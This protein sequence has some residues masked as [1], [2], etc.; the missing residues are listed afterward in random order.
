MFGRKLYEEFTLVVRLKKQV[1]VTDPDWQD[2]LHHVRHGCCRVHHIAMLQSLV[3]TNPK[4]VQTDF[5]TAPWNECVLITPRHS[6]RRQWNA[7][8]LREHCKRRGVPLFI[9]RAYDSV[10]GRVVT[11][12]EKF[13]IAKKTN[14]AKSRSDE[15]G[16]LPNVVELAIGM[17]VMVTFN[18]ETDLDVANGA[19]G[20]IVEIKLD[21]R[22]TQITHASSTNHLQYPPL[23]I[24]VRLGRTKAS[25]LH[26][27]E[28]NVVPIVPMQRSFKIYDNDVEKNISRQQLPITAAYA[29]TDYRSQG[30]TI[31]YALIDIASPPTGGLTPFN[32]YVALSR[33]RGKDN[34][35]LLREFD[36]KPLTTHPNGHLRNE[37]ERLQ[38]LDERTKLWWEMIQKKN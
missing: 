4:G 33:A 32:I 5:T 29:F 25:Q 11:L 20:E 17:K 18:I 26:S 38:L 2:L 23:Y 30:Q 37:N 12:A 28:K 16:G 3:I 31:P 1:R 22:E 19:R 9:C 10:Q 21:E 13:S 36:E 8:M 35:R 24:L 15:R 14:R 34:I 6:V 27:L 7:K